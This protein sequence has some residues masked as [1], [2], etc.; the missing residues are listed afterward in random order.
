MSATREV[1][2]FA[3]RN[4]G[5]FTARE[6]IE[7]G[8]PKAT[9]SRRVSDGVFVR[10]TRGI[11]ALPGTASRPEARLRAAG[12]LLGAVVSHETAAR[13]HGLTPV[14]KTPPTVTVPYR[15]TYRFPGVTVH[16]STDLLPEH[17]LRVRGQLATNPA[18]TIID[19]ASKLGKK[20][21]GR[22]LDNALVAGFVDLDDVIALHL[23]LS[24]QGKKGMRK[25]GEIL[26]NRAGELV[27]AT[28]LERE[29]FGLLQRAGLPE[30]VREFKAP[31]L[32]E[33]EGRVDFAYVDREILLE[34]DSRR[35]HGFP[36]DFEN[37]RRRDIAAQL[38]GWIVLRITW[39]M[40]TEDPEYVI[41][42]VRAALELRNPVSDPS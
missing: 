6:A 29:L 2:A 31:W 36:D 8:M 12:R 30:P 16:Q 20:R 18:R 28:V 41:N 15:R 17:T 42:S 1:I 33:I 7:R 39:K 9:L 27:P 35:W 40:I 34:A 32:A 3:R 37:D 13:L 5:F 11:Y 23:A 19:L 22:L 25:L 24:R 26:R 4:D 10:I 38:S 14:P 21:L